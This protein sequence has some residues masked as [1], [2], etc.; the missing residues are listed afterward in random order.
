MKER[1]FVLKKETSFKVAYMDSHT[2][3]SCKDE[4]WELGSRPCDSWDEA[5]I[6]KNNW[7]D[8]QGY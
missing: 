7:Q 6:I 8:G 4:G 3:L 2:A 5:K 1:W